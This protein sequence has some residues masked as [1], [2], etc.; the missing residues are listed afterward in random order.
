MAILKRKKIVAKKVKKTKPRSKPRAKIVA[1]KPY[2]ATL[3]RSEGNPII[4]PSNY[5]NWESVATFNPSAVLH[6]GKVHIVYRAIGA[7]DM[8]ALG[9]AKSD[10][11]FIISYRSPMPMYCHKIEKITEKSP[12]PV[13]YF[14]GGGGTGGCED[15]RLT[16]LD[17]KIYLLYT[18]F[19]GWDSV[20]IAVTTISLEDFIAK[21]W[22]NWKKPVFISPPG[23]IHKNW[24][25]FPEKINGKYAI[26]SAISPI[27]MI[28]YFDSLNE[29]DGTKYI[30]SIH[31]DSPLWQLRD[32]GIRGVG[33]TPIKTKYGWLVLYHATELHDSHRYKLWAMILDK[34]DPTKVLYRSRR[35]ILEPDE[36]Y[37]NEGLKS[38]VIYSC[39]AVVKG[40]NL[41][42]YY[43]GADMVACVA[44]A[45]LDSFLKELTSKGVPKLTSKKRK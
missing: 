2:G 30:K 35:P 5:P 10:D 15:P 9:Y 20:R 6:D 1:Y 29:F 43:G 8:S 39:G 19:N 27:I 45:D 41:F 13:S 24:V 34:K 40:K 26:L 25:L 7:G 33:P 22:Q 17:G 32:R 23:E 42:V 18:A 38:G 3:E 16:L 31:Q 28:H 36:Q 12:S 21:R 11:G 37:E 14:S 4:T 44:T